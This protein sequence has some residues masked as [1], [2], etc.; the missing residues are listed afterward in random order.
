MTVIFRTMSKIRKSYYI[1]IGKLEGK[2]PA[3]LLGPRWADDIKM[4]L[5]RTGYGVT[6]LAQYGFQLKVLVNNRITSSVSI[7]DR[8]VFDWLTLLHTDSLD[9]GL[10]TN[11]NYY[12]WCYLNAI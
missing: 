11:S 1:L 2:R 3:V 9:L 8:E 4:L 10:I 12:Y 6:K 7:K 5:K